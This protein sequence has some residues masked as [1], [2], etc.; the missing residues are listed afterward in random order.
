MRLERHLR[1]VQSL[2]AT[3]WV[4]L[5]CPLLSSRV[6]ITA[7]A[8]LAKQ[9]KWTWE[10]GATYPRQGPWLLETLLD[11]GGLLEEVSSREG[12]LN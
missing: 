7:T 2:P 1:F 4:E 6:P 11:A 3:H 8:A 10:M 9:N 5:P 12:R